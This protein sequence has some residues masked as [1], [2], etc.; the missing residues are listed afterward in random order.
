MRTFYTTV[1]AGGRLAYH[2]YLPDASKLPTEPAEVMAEVRAGR[3]QLRGPSGRLI[4]REEI[5]Q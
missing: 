1:Q 3:A 2:E 5:I 4:E